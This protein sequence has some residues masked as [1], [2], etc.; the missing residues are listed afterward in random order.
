MTQFSCQ[1]DLVAHETGHNWNAQHCSCSSSTMNA[2]ITC[3][4]TFT[5]AGSN[6]VNQILAYKNSVS[7]LGPCIP[8]EPPSN[9]TCANRIVVGE[10]S[11][12]YTNEHATTDGPSESDKCSFFGDPQIQ[13]D[14][15]FQ[16]TATCTGELTVAACDGTFNTKVGL[17]L[18]SSCPTQSNTVDECD[19]TSC[20]NNRAMATIA[21]EEGD[22]VIIRVGSRSGGA[23][24]D[25]TINVTC[26][27][28]APPACPADLNGDD[29][30]DGADLLVLLGSWGNCPGCDADLNGDDVVDGADLLI[31]LGAWGGCP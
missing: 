22:T 10:G 18:G 17:Y 5:G 25:G 31:L 12:A 13:H 8:P 16:H 29:V 24:G 3:A 19:T 21:V 11:T 26:E 28:V 15:W 27:E 2:S 4:N 7:C 6:S 14:V 30:V 9:N 23:T 20:P 1:T